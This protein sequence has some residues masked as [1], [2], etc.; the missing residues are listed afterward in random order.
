MSDLQN[1]PGVYVAASNDW[2]SQSN[3]YQQSLS[4]VMTFLVPPNGKS[5]VPKLVMRIENKE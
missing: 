4:C 2:P 1:D 3:S 5:P